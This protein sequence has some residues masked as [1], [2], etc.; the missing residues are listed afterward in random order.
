MPLISVE[1]LT[2]NVCL[3]LWELR[4]T[5]EELF[6]SYPFL[7]SCDGIEACMCKSSRRSAERLVE[8]LL[9][10]ELFGENVTLLHEDSGR[11]FLSNDCNIS[12]SHT[13]G[14]VAVIVS[15]TLTVAV[16]AEYI[17]DRVNRI[18]DRFLRRDEMA[19]D[20]FARLL[21]WCSKE[22][23][24]KFYSADK[25][26]FND[27]RLLSVH[28]TNESGSVVAENLKRGE[29]LD[30]YYRVLNNILITYSFA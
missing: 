12:I 4:E 16:D 27:M 24:Y 26:E 3:A 9:I 10:K 20:V 22:T 17:S 15:E 5:P 8:R 7:L 1:K 25:L 28:G 23:L 6:L 13:E 21:H 14:C 30:V 18:A 19:E 2:G 29:C 11:P